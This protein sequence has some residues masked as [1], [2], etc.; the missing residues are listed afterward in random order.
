MLFGV[1]LPNTL[2]QSYAHESDHLQ[3]LSEDNLGFVHNQKE[4]FERRFLILLALNI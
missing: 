3:I 4:E 1:T 2:R